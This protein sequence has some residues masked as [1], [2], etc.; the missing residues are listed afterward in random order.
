MNKSTDKTNMVHYL[1]TFFVFIRL[2]ID[3]DLSIR[4]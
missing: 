4:A 3:S 1:R 2:G